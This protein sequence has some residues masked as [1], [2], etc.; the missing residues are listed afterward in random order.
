[1]K[2]SKEKIFIFFSVL[3]HFL[4]SRR[5]EIRWNPVIEQFSHCNFES[6]HS[7]AS[8]RGNKWIGMEFFVHFLSFLWFFEDWIM[9][10][11]ESIALK[12]LKWTEKLWKYSFEDLVSNL[13][14]LWSTVWIVD[15]LSEFLAN[16]STGSTNIPTGSDL[17]A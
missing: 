9:E 16:M 10:M 11:T 4:Q 3:F 13:E 1:M 8:V 5:D 15:I 6:F 17:E 7:Y 12:F 14:V 2:N